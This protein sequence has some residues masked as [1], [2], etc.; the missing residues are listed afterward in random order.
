MNYEHKEII[1]TERHMSQ[2]WHFA[3][4]TIP[5]LIYSQIKKHGSHILTLGAGKEISTASNFSPHFPYPQACK[6]QPDPKH[7]QY[8]KKFTA[9]SDGMRQITEIKI[10]K[11]S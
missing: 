6:F 11:D 10:S 1:L 8:T 9:L 5:T 2:Q 3:K 4:Q 7:T